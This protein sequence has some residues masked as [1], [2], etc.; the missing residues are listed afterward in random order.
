MSSILKVDTIQDQAGN[1]II[2]ENAN[3]V[4]IG[5]AGASV[6]ITGNVIKS[7]AYQAADAET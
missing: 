3:V 7:D 5:K 2:N 1:N 4:T 6:V